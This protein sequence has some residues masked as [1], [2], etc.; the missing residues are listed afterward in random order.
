MA[1]N[2]RWSIVLVLSVFVIVANVFYFSRLVTKYLKA[3]NA[4]PTQEITAISRFAATPT[5][6]VTPTQVLP[7]A[8]IAVIRQN[9]CDVIELTYTKKKLGSMEIKLNKSSGVKVYSLDKNIGFKQI[10]DTLLVLPIK[11]LETRGK[12]LKICGAEP[13]EVVGYEFGTG[14][15]IQVSLKQ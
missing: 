6:S 9:G 5:V 1:D 3:K 15:K 11:P 8:E 14:A 4:Q 2:T 12:L 7:T 10:E 13:V